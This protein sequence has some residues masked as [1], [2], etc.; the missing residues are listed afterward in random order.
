MEMSV[1]KVLQSLF[2]KSVW[3]QFPS[4][5]LE[6]HH[7]KFAEITWCITLYIPFQRITWC[8]VLILVMPSFIVQT[9]TLEKHF[10]SFCA[11]AENEWTGL[12]EA[13]SLYMAEAVV[14]ISLGPCLKCGCWS[15]NTNQPL[16]YFFVLVSRLGVHIHEISPRWEWWI[17][18]AL[19]RKN[20][21]WLVSFLAQKMLLC[22]SGWMDKV[23]FGLLNKDVW[24]QTVTRLTLLSPVW[25]GSI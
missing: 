10:P 8:P 7:Y 5:S 25:P 20:G 16:V 24:A 14:F 9:Q 22:I 2:C 13:S 6:H 21:V 12:S 15:G 11:Q 18:P 1:V 19:L 23:L 4:I 3:R 17:F